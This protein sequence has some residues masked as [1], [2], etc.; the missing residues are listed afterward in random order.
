MNGDDISSEKI[1]LEKVSQ[2]YIM[3]FDMIPRG[4]KTICKF[5]LS[6][7]SMETLRSI[8]PIINDWYESDLYVFL[9]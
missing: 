7:S 4:H 2:G 6:G 8:L 3:P 1:V 9:K 5:S